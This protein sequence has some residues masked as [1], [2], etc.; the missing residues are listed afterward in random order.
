MYILVACEES[1]AVTK[2]L[3]ALGHEAFS[4]DIEECSGGH[5]EWHIQR[6]VLEVLDGTFCRFGQF[7]TQAGSVEPAVHRWDM[8][9]AFPPCTYL[10]I[11]G[12]R[13]FNIDRYG[14]KAV[15][16]HQLRAE[17]AAFFLRLASADC[18]RIAIE[19]PVGAMSKLWRKP[20]QY[21]QPYEFGH[22]ES[23]KTGLWLKGLPKLQPT[24]IVTPDFI[25][26]KDGKKYSYTHW[27]S[28]GSPHKMRD[29]W[30][31]MTDSGQ[32]KLTPSEMRAKIRSKTYSGI[33]RAMATQWAG[34]V[35]VQ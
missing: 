14:Q 11:S 20:D 17:A 7:W 15:E 1:Q 21:V 19:N 23:K 22:K 5:P 29:V 32:N 33:A 12:N 35:D 25:I 6:D 3:R 26:G 31:N 16:R 10:T 4:C 8:I 34:G 13:W 2:E 30:D 24:D 9:I 28:L 27:K 18:D